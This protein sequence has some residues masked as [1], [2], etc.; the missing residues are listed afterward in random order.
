MMTFSP[1]SFSQSEWNELVSR[2]Q[3]LSLLQMWEYGEAKA[4]TGPWKVERGLI[5]D[6][7]LTVGATQV[8]VRAVFG[9]PR[10]AWIYRG[11]LPELHVPHDPDV[12][13]VALAALRR[14][15]VEQRGLYLRIAPPIHLGTS[16]IDGP[17]IAGYHRTGIRGWASA[18]LDLTPDVG[19]LRKQL[20]P[21]WRSSLAKAERSEIR[22]Q[23]GDSIDGF[24]RFLDDYRNLLSQRNF[25]TTVTP[26]LLTH[27]HTATPDSTKPL[28]IEGSL[29]LQ[30]LGSILIVRYGSTGEYLASAVRDA[31]RNA[32]V[33][34]LLLWRAICELKGRGYRLFDL[35]G[36][37][38][39][40]TPAGI[41]HFKAGLGAQRYQFMNEIEARRA[42][43]STW[44]VRHF[45]NKV[46]RTGT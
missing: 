13:E 33:G 27:L 18:R 31:G 24:T 20:R 9:I 43:L 45:V 19:V 11:P 46:R 40:R 36:M 12:A 5:R 29:G 6:G 3:G 4:H 37:H 15:W 26:E 14:Y 39:E 44:L 8:L 10:L 21:N 42:T 41:Y 17:V 32:S 34:Q 1:R 35:G 2:Y 25:D 38:E 16:D 30:R 22:V 7:D 23:V 28:V